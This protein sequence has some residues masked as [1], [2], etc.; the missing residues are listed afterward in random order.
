MPISGAGAARRS[1][2]KPRGARFDHRGAIG[3]S[4]VPLAD[5]CEGVLVVRRPIDRL[6]EIAKLAIPKIEFVG[7]S[8][9]VGH[10]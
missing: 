4:S 2:R 9:A 1:W 7:C 5:D 8:E 3:E 6:V 10:E